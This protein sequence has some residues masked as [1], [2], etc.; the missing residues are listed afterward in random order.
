MN[1]DIIQLYHHK[2]VKLFGKDLIDISLKA[3][4]DI[5]QP[6]RYYLVF[7]VPIS[8]L[9]DGFLFINFLNSYLIVNTC[10]IQ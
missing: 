8:S 6:K 1:Q 7:E 5:R 4:Q 10:Q 2:D 9:K 3:G